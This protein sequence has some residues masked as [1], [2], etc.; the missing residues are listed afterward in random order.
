MYKRPV[1]GINWQGNRKDGR[2]TARNFPLKPILKAAEN[3]NGTI[4]SLQ[5]KSKHSENRSP[6]QSKNLT[7][8]QEQIHRLADSNSD[9]AFIEYAAV[10]ANCD[11]VITTATTTCHLAAAMGITTW[12]LL[13]KVPDWRWG[14]EG[15]T[16]FWYP[17]MRLFRQKDFGIWDDVFIHVAS[18]LNQKFSR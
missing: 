15:E 12:V 17:S 18:E 6:W 7:E 5:R 11:L 9:S 8:I 10:I 2:K 4:I 3:I 16:S 14:L 1:I 13:H